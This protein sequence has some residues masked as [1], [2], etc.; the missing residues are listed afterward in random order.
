M[1]QTGLGALALAP[2]EFWRMTPRELALAIEGRFG[3]PRAP[4][5]RHDLE[6]LMARFPDEG[7]P[8]G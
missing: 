3:P 7:T 6:R 5:E 8:N 1:M 2:S 4:M